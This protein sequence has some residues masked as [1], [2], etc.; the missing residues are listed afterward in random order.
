MNS[1]IIAALIGGGFIIIGTFIGNFFST[2][3]IKSQARL[4][5]LAELYAEVF[6]KYTFAIP[7]TDDEKTLSFISAVEKTKLFC[8]SESEQL[9]TTLEQTIAKSGS[10][11]KEC[12]DLLHRLRASAKKDLGKGAIL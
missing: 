4:K 1:E 10:N 5:L 2:K 11:A 7:F 3:T 6:S 9:L 8:S 12:R